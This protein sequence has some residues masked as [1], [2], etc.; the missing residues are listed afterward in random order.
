MQSFVGLCPH[1]WN[2]TQRREFQDWSKAVVVGASCCYLPAPWF[3]RTY[4]AFGA[5]VFSF[6][7]YIHKR[8]SWTVIL[9][10]KLNY[11][12]NVLSSLAVKH[13]TMVM[14]KDTLNE[15]HVFNN[16]KSAKPLPGLGLIVS[17][18]SK[19]WANLLAL[20]LHVDT[21]KFFPCYS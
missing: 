11:M 19:P 17:L 2:R 1:L 18:A 16:L 3:E 21:S 8:L 4:V 5:Y 13:C 12:Y 9:R 20:P 6:E 7:K 15:C 10:I 14:I